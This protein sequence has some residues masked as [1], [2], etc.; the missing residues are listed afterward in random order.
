M[1]HLPDPLG[2]QCHPH[3]S[4]GWT[5]PL[6]FLISNN[7]LLIV[8]WDFTRIT[9]HIHISSTSKLL[10]PLSITHFQISFYVFKYLLQQYFFT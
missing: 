3:G 8:V 9:L 10:Q 6:C 2:W 1:S 4:A 5:R 7:M